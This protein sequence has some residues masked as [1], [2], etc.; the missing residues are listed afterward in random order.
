MRRLTILAATALV[1]AALCAPVPASAMVSNSPESPPPVAE[2]T[3]APAD[4]SASG[5]QAAQ[6]GQGVQTPAPGA[7]KPVRAII[8]P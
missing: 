7:D 3:Q 5:G 1:L 6:P 2:T 8:K 4:Q